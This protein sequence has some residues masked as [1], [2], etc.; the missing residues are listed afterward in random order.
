MR[1]RGFSFAATEVAVS[2]AIPAPT[3]VAPAVAAPAATD[4]ATGATPAALAFDEENCK[5]RIRQD[6][7]PARSSDLMCGAPR[8]RYVVDRT[9]CIICWQ[10]YANMA[11]L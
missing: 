3:V 5:A 11:P 8:A 10:L 2:A 9:D 1:K 7:T 4:A 6:T